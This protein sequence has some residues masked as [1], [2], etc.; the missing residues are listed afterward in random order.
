MIILI[1]VGYILLGCLV[2]LLSQI[3]GKCEYEDEE[4]CVSILFWPCLL[5]LLVITSL[6]PWILKRIYKLFVFIVFFTI[7]LFK[8]NKQENQD[9]KN[10][11]SEETVFKYEA[12]MHCPK[13][14]CHFT[15][16]VSSIIANS[17]N[18][19]QEISVLS[20]CPSCHEPVCCHARIKLKKY[21]SPK[22]GLRE[23][24]F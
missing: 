15:E 11:V 6:L 23:E 2:L 14:D 5:V 7:S 3:W 19:P 8:K 21:Y 12:Q 20:T 22:N 24:M 16:N 17:E 9:K 18:V 13:C 1:L 4:I 10:R